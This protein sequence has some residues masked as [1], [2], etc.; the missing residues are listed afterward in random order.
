MRAWCV[1]TARPAQ[2]PVI[3]V[4]TASKPG[5]L[6]DYHGFPP[7]AYQLRY[8]APGAPEVANKVLALLRWVR[9]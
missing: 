4:S 6:Y 8:D 7:E 5:M 3:T 2:E 1:C 9:A